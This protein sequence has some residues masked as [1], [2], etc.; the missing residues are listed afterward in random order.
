MVSLSKGRELN[1]LTMLPNPTVSED[2]GVFGDSMGSLFTER[3]SE[4]DC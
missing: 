3:F 2:T 1:H 4:C